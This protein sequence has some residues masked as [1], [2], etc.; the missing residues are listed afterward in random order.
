MKLLYFMQQYSQGEVGTLHDVTL[1]WETLLAS[2]GH[3]SPLSQTSSEIFSYH[4]R[5]F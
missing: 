2:K 3:Q 1:E 5:L 4:V